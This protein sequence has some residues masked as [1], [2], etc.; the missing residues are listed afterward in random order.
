MKNRLA[1]ASPSDGPPG[2]AF[3][4]D[5]PAVDGGTAAVNFAEHISLPLVHWAERLVGPSAASVRLWSF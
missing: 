1:A 2:A 5:G 3:F 4:V